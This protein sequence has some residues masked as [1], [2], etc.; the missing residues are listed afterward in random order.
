MKLGKYLG[1][2]M[3]FFVGLL[4]YTQK[5]FHNTIWGLV[6]LICLI[7]WYRWVFYPKN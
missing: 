7:L 4:L 5:E 2:Y 1:T 3:L 6:G